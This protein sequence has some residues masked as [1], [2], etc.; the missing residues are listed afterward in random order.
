M[1]IIYSYK[2]LNLFILLCVFSVIVN[3]TFHNMMGA[4]QSSVLQLTVP[5]SLSA[6]VHLVMS[7]GFALDSTDSF[8]KQL[9]SWYLLQEELDIG[10]HLWQQHVSHMGLGHSQHT[11]GSRL[12]MDEVHRKQKSMKILININVWV[13]CSLGFKKQQMVSWHYMLLHHANE[14]K[15]INLKTI[16]Q[17]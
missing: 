15:I 17:Q 6:Q 8:F 3:L 5:Y 9:H 14:G 13:C 2:M 16:K 12:R 10:V 7:W 4:S 11:C 1:Y